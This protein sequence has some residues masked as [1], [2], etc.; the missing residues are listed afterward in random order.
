MRM[1]SMS[2]SESE[3]ERYQRQLLVE[4]WDQEKLK[5]ARVLIVGVGGLGGT[6]AMYLAAAGVGH[7]RICDGDTVER[8]NLNRQILFTADDIGRPKA[9]LAAE[10]LSRHNPEIHVEAIPETLTDANARDAASG[11]NLIIDGLDNH[12]DRLMLNQASFDLQI[13]FVYGAVN[14]WLGQV[15][16]FHPPQT[17][18][19]ACLLPRDLPVPRPIPVYGAM[20]GVIGSLQAT[21]ALWYLM[22]GKDPL[23]NALLIFHADTMNFES[24]SLERRPECAICGKA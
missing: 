20:P 6:S 23:A 2:L 9:A 24:V 10:R 13:P 15:G 19:L 16:F 21:L 5:R 3:I 1:R 12:S 22:T 14:E 8:S 4:G 7:L 18:C 17:A 11:C